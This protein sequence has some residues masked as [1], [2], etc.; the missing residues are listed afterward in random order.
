MKHAPTSLEKL[1][2][3]HRPIADLKIIS[4]VD[5]NALERVAVWVTKHIGSMGFFSLVLGWT[6]LWLIWNIF[7]PLEFRFDPY[8][9]FVLWLFISNMVQLL[10]LPLIMIGQNLQNKE[11]NMRSK[12]DFEVNL[13]SEKE[14]ETIIEHLE[15]QDEL[16]KDIR[17]HITR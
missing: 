17:D 16:L 5:L 12:R 6:I 9:A 1:R 14:I 10:I 15:N 7:G 4:R 2:V 3:A 13:K 11:A 8:P